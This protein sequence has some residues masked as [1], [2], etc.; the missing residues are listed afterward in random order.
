MSRKNANLPNQTH[1]PFTIPFHL[2]GKHRRRADAGTGSENAIHLAACGSDDST[3]RPLANADA[4]R[5]AGLR[6][7]DRADWFV[8]DEP[9]DAS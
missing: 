5:V 1:L 2:P 4:G 6:D 7:Q 8:D 3:S 9:D